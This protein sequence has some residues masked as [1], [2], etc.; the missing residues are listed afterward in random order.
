[1]NESC[2][3][4]DRLSEIRGGM[5]RIPREFEDEVDE[6]IEAEEKPDGCENEWGVGWRGYE[7]V[8]GVEG[9]VDAEL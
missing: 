5:D 6:I 9:D 1:M 3:N 2:L 7:G 8:L 4:A